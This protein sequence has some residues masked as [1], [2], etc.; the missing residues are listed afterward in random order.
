MYVYVGVL[1]LAFLRACVSVCVAYSRT[2]DCEYLVCMCV[3][4]CVCVAYVISESEQRLN[5][6]ETALF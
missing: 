5:T 6:S 2:W 1:E 4:V 3:C